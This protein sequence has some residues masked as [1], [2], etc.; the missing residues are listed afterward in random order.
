MS[1]TLADIALTDIQSLRRALKTLHETYGVQR[2]V[3]SSI[4]L[5]PWLRQA[6]PK[7]ILPPSADEIEHLLCITSQKNPPADGHS[8]P[9]TV[10]AQTVLQL[11]GYYSGVG[12]LF[13]AL[14]LG[15]YDSLT[16]EANVLPP[17]AHAVTQALVKTH[18]VISYTYDSL[19][20]DGREFTDE[21]KDKLDPLRRTRRMKA[22]EL[23]L[24]ESQDIIRAPLIRDTEQ[25]LEA[26]SEF[27]TQ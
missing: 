8:S 25:M 22:R 10:Y 21:E 12:D 9:S 1:R 26:W 24:I 6:L 7:N 15:H 18:K 3:I 19:Q 5:H 17:L 14:C 20:D 23:R 27:W 11:R 16:P 2:I 13:S 4:P